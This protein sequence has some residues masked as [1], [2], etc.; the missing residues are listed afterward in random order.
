M[1]ENIRKK[2]L[3]K[4]KK[5]KYKQKDSEGNQII[6]NETPLNVIQCKNGQAQLKRES[7]DQKTPRSRERK[8][9]TSPPE[10]KMMKPRSRGSISKS[11][12]GDHGMDFLELRPKL[13][14]K[15]YCKRKSSHP[16]SYNV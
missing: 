3:A 9:T 6:S 16:N 12:R 15:N 13:K 5:S 10:R 2:N 8:T 4:S 11:D 7:I 1:N 14:K